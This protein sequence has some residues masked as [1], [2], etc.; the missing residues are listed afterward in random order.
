MLLWENTQFF[1]TSRRF[2]VSSNFLCFEEKDIVRSQLG[3]IFLQITAV[4]EY[5]MLLNKFYFFIEFLLIGSFCR[6]YFY[7]TL[8]SSLLF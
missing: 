6:E 2:A 8:D 3:G 5:F 4:Q 7:P 1:L